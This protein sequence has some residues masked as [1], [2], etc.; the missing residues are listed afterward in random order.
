ML[1]AVLIKHTGR[2]FEG[3][4]KLLSVRF[5]LVLN[6]CFLTCLCKPHF[7]KTIAPSNTQCREGISSHESRLDK[8]QTPLT[9]VWRQNTLFKQYNPFLLLCFW[10]PEINCLLLL[11]C[12]FKKKQSTKQKLS[13]AYVDYEQSVKDVLFFFLNV[14]FY[15][16]IHSAVVMTY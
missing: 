6:P 10:N 5:A 15:W 14:S 1:G 12:I 8:A 13:W 11:T 7:P 16:A 4:R 3:Y 2:H 9:Q